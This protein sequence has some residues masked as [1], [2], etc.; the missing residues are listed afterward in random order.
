LAAGTPRG[1]RLVAVRP[2]STLSLLRAPWQA[3]RLTLPLAGE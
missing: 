1:V 3:I 2:D